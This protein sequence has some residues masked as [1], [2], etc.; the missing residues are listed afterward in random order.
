[1]K[2][3][4]D[5]LTTVKD[6]KLMIYENKKQVPLGHQRL[7]L[8]GH[9]RLRED[10]LISDLYENRGLRTLHLEDDR[11]A[12]SSAGDQT[13]GEEVFYSKNTSYDQ[14]RQ[15]NGSLYDAHVRPPVPKGKTT[16]TGNESRDKSWQV[17]GFVPAIHIFQN[18]D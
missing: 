4:F 5:Q 12:M 11:K 13:S 18:T 14:S 15:V 9:G 6:L 1:V 16:Y 2:F 7:L 8:P 10:E 3:T 17:N